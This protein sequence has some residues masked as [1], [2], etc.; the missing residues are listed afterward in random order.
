[1]AYIYHT[2][3]DCGSCKHMNACSSVEHCMR[4]RRRNTHTADILQLF[5]GRLLRAPRAIIKLD[6]G[7]LL[8]VR[9]DELTAAD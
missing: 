8:E 4:C 2:P 9:L 7:R 6:N 5:P 1:M 3:V